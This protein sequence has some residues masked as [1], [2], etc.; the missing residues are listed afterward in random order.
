MS[1]FIVLDTETNSFTPGQITQLSYLMVEDNKIKRG[2]NYFFSVETINKG[3]VDLTGRNKA[4]LDVLSHGDVFAD[5]A[6]EIH[7][8]L[9]NKTI[10]AHNARF[11]STFLKAEFE[12]LNIDFDA[13]FRC[14]MKE[15]AEAIKTNFDFHKANISQ[16]ELSDLLNIPNLFVK[17]LVSKYFK[18]S[19]NS[20]RH[21][22]CWDVAELYLIYNELIKKGYLHD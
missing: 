21:D 5:C 7:T 1:N 10:I 4:T 18:D 8:D 19:A 15:S 11:D 14:T 9:N 6:E 2:V 12:R 17:T 22:S 20:Y 3:I 16:E 13:N